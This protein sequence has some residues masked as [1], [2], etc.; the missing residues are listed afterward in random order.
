MSDV[1]IVKVKSMLPSAQLH[2]LRRNILDQKESGVIVLPA[3][4]DVLAVPEDVEIK[5]EGD[6]HGD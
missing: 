6:S 1:L 3:F 2:H 5:V 4:C